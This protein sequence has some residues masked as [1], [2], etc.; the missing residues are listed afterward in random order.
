MNLESYGWNASLQQ[1]LDEFEDPTLAPARVARQERTEW[2]VISGAGP[3]SA[4]LAGR[5]RHEPPVV[6]DWVAGRPDALGGWTIHARLPRRGTLAREGQVVA[7]HVDVTLACAAL[8]RPFNARRVERF[9]AVAHETRAVV[10]LTKADLAQDAAAALAQARAL[11]APAILTSAARGIGLDEARALVAPG[12]TVAIL[13]PSGAGK[14]S[15]A[16]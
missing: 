16:N 13:G 6:G 8:D 10:V 12:V 7:A 4:R 2:R 1:A 15:L 3:V 9:L 11:G 5:A 14:S